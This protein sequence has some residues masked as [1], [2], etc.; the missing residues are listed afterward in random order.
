MPNEREALRITGRDTLPEAV[1]WFETSGVRVLTLKKGAAGAEVHAG[2]E[3]HALATTAVTGGDGIGAGDSF[4]A[5]FLAA[6]LR[7][8]PLD[9]LPPRRLHLRTGRRLETRRP[10]KGSRPGMCVMQ[11]LATSSL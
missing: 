6:W 2:P 1:R 7:G 11:S 10:R 4:D 9:Q 5:G 8:M 3:H